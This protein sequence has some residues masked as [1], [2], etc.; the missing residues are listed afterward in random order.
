MGCALQAVEAEEGRSKR[1]SIRCGRN[2][3]N[4]RR[5]WPVPGGRDLSHAIHRSTDAQ[6]YPNRC[7]VYLTCERP[8]PGRVDWMHVAWPV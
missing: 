3:S 8:G 7:T 4:R 5:T 1:Q 6:A 2:A